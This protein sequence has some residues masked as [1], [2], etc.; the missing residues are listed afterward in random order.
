MQSKISYNFE[1]YIT[2]LPSDKGGRKNSIATNFR[3]NFSFNTKKYY[4]GEII[5]PDNKI[6]SPGE[7]APVYISLIEAITIPTNLSIHS[8]FTISEGKKVIGNG[9]ITALHKSEMPVYDHEMAT[10]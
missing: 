10:K 3:P 9:Q 2:L 6:I 5:I 1:A 4:C 7:S 8:L